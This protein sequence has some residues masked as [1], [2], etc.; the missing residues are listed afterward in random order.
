MQN[1]KKAWP[2]VYIALKFLA[3][4][5]EL[6]DM[7]VR[8]LSRDYVALS[9]I[10]C[11]IFAQINAGEPQI[12]L[13][14]LIHHNGYEQSSDPIDVLMSLIFSIAEIDERDG[15]L[16]SQVHRGKEVEKQYIFDVSF[17]AKETLESSIL[18][19]FEADHL[20]FVK[21]ADW[22]LLR[23]SE[24][25]NERIS[26][27]ECLDLTPFGAGYYDFVSY[28]M[29]QDD[30]VTVGVRD[31]QDDKWLEER[32]EISKLQKGIGIF[33]FRKNRER[34]IPT[35]VVDFSVVDKSHRVLGKKEQL[36]KMEIGRRVKE[37]VKEHAGV[38]AFYVC[39]N[40]LGEDL[41]EIPDSEQF[42][43]VYL[44]KS[45]K[46]L[47]DCL[48]LADSE[49]QGSSSQKDGK[50]VQA[51][52]EQEPREQCNA[53]ES[54]EV[55]SKGKADTSPTTSGSRTSDEPRSSPR[56][57]KESKVVAG[58]GKVESRPATSGSRTRSDKTNVREPTREGA[59]SSTKRGT[60]SSSGARDEN[61]IIMVTSYRTDTVKSYT[62]KLNTSLDN[63]P[64]EICKQG[65]IKL[66]S[67][68]DCYVE[69]DN[70]CYRLPRTPD[71]RLRDVIREYGKNL[72]IT[73]Q[74]CEPKTK[75]ARIRLSVLSEADHCWK[76]IPIEILAFMQPDDVLDQ[77]PKEMKPKQSSPVFYR[78]VD[79]GIQE[80]DLNDLRHEC[81]KGLM[82]Q[83]V[84]EPRAKVL[85]SVPEGNKVSF[86]GGCHVTESDSKTLSDYGKELQ[87]LLGTTSLPTIGYVNSK[88]HL[89][90]P[91]QTQ[92]I[93]DLLPHGEHE[94]VAIFD[95]KD[96]K[97]L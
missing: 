33:A 7:L 31:I 1:G 49:A 76:P 44:A 37:Y 11:D 88:G 57:A 12:D 42:V 60:A 67:M 14:P 69:R 17:S 96:K 15:T 70:L 19:M 92:T 95:A 34:R 77:I 43:H 54:K 46:E 90:K 10:L 47:E 65:K 93:E 72:F 87:Q 59:T 16:C 53:K 68:N 51:A 79:D 39:G 45:I 36:T 21:P 58:K 2:A 66:Q 56:N 52:A 50:G 20:E 29:V 97:K 32:L 23:T 9:P 38:R 91:D 83:Y 4:M 13:C 85:L 22:L 41:S 8:S 55:A 63:L 80:Y 84:A 82:L 27:D 94:L 5:E 3:Q 78:I 71:I 40:G 81:P 86:V 61:V 30:G 73:T 64:G 18:S 48:T 24:P 28:I 89:T 25:F 62:L 26:Y 6:K 74:N 35:F 75:P